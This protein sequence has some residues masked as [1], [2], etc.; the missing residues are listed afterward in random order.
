MESFHKVKVPASSANLG[1]GFDT[2]AVSLKIFLT[3]EIEESKYFEVQYLD[4]TYRAPSLRNHPIAKISREVL[5]HDKIKAKIKSQIPV[6]RGLGSSGALIVASLLAMGIEDPFELASVFEGHPDNVAASLYGGLVAVTYNEEK[7]P[8]YKRLKVDKS[9]GCLLFIPEVTI[10]TNDARK[11]LPKHVPLKEA[12]ANLGSLS[13]LISGF[14]DP[15]SFDKI[16]GRDYLH[17]N[18]RALLYK[19]ANDIIEAFYDCG[20]L[21]ACWSGAGSSIIAFGQKW[22]MEQIST[23]MGKALSR[24][25]AKGQLRYADIDFRG[26]VIL[27]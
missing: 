17:Q 18:Q 8:V 24:L 9:L 14:S 26:A 7:K 12:V 11:V 6:S 21:H 22:R 20:A 19:R 25:K 10:P 4:N 1:P 13:F 2:L 3:L 15:K 23:K 16:A 27:K 5:G